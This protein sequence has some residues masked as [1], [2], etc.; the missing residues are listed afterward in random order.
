MVKKKLQV[1]DISNELQG[2]KFFATKQPNK[3]PFKAVAGNSGRVKTSDVRR[4]DNTDKDHSPTLSPTSGVSPSRHKEPH[5]KVQKR[6]I[7]ILQFNKKE[8]EQLK[9]IA[10][11]PHTFRIDTKEIQ[12]IKDL[13]HELNKKNRHRKVSQGDILRIAIRLLRKVV[14]SDDNKSLITLL[15]RIK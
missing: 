7:T 11:L 14:I 6:S 8:I 2:S 13:T 9:S 15:K 3:R 10:Q 12:W 5:K 4:E 1:K